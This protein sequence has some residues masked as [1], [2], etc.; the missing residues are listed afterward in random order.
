MEELPDWLETLWNINPGLARRAEIYIDDLSK[1]NDDKICENKNNLLSLFRNS[2]Y[3]IKHLKETERNLDSE[4]SNEISEIM[5]EESVLRNYKLALL[6]PK[7]DLHSEI[8]KIINE[9][10]LE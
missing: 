7:C 4:I 9:Y 6:Q 5:K 1:K 3:M 10:G 2:K 8:K